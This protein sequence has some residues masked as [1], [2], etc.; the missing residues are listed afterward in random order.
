MTK[1]KLSKTKEYHCE[2]A[3]LEV[4]ELICELMER[5]GVRRI[6]LADRLGKTKGYITQLLEGRNMTIRTIS[7]ICFALGFELHFSA[8][9]EGAK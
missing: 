2:R 4:T 5:E 6:D 7:D 1:V 9:K 8:S 3:I